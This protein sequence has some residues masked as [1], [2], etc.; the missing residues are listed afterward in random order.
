MDPKT[1][2]N[3]DHTRLELAAELMRLIDLDPVIMDKILPVLKF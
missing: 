3:L 1:L 2:N